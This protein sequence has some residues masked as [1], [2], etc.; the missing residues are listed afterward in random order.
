MEDGERKTKRTKF[1]LAAAVLCS[2]KN[3]AGAHQR[4]GKI[5]AERWATKRIPPPFRTSV[6]CK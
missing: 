2:F 1:L 6:D 5:A 4:I 3:K